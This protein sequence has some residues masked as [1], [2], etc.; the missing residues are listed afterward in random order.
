MNQTAIQADLAAELEV[1]LRSLLDD[2][3]VSE[4]RCT[5]LEAEL[6]ETKNQLLRLTADFDNFRKRVVSQ[7]PSHPQEVGCLGF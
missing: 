4:D 6:E 3:A 2:K 1:T 5:S 7:E